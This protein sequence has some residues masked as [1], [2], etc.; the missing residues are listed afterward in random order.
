MTHKTDT[1]AEYEEII[2]PT[3]LL[4]NS[5]IED[6]VFIIADSGEMPEVGLQSSIYFLSADPDGP[7]LT[8]AEN[9]LTPLN[10]AVIARY[11]A[12]ILRDLTPDN[13]KKN[14]YRGIARSAANWQRMKLFTQRAQLD[15]S[16]V[17][18]KTAAAL[19]AFLK[20]EVCYVTRGGEGCCPNCS[21]QTLEDFAEELGL[22][23]DDLSCSWQD[24]CCL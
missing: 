5:F 11:Q 16:S 4:V 23:A 24:L 1:I 18:Q 2:S 7:H 9:D 3:N 14:L 19:I 15:I 10:K 6:E 13:R 17:R 12:I 8:L 20:E 21:Q 22:S